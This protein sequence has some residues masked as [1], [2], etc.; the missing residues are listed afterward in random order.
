MEELL[1]ETS[2][3]ADE[4]DQLFM[5]H[6]NNDSLLVA[7]RTLQ[8]KVTRYMEAIEKNING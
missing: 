7:M 4:I 5:C 1:E 3:I 6:E 2:D 8:K